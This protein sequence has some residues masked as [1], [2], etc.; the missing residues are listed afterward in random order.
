MPLFS[1]VVSAIVI[2]AVTMFLLVGVSYLA[3]RIKRKSTYQRN[4]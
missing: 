4:Y 3:Y 1:V 2:V